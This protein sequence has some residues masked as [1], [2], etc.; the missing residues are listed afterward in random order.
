V[1]EGRKE[2]ALSRGGFFF[3]VA[4]MWRDF[5]LGDTEEGG[6]EG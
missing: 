2:R 4:G 3:W 1:G 5:G 6:M